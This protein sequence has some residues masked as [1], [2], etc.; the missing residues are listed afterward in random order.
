MQT[1]GL[2]CNI[3]FVIFFAFLWYDGVLDVRILPEQEQEV[4]SIQNPSL[5]TYLSQFDTHSDEELISL[6][7]D[8]GH[9]LNGY[10]V[11]ELALALLKERGYVVADP[12]QAYNGWPQP[13]Q[14]I[15]LSDKKTIHLF[16][17]LTSE[18]IAQ[19]KTYYEQVVVPFTAERIVQELDRDNE[20]YSQALIRTDEWARFSEV[21]PHL[22]LEERIALAREL[23]GALF[24]ETPKK[25]PLEL[26]QVS[27]SPLLALYLASYEMNAL[28]TQAD[29]RTLSAIFAL[30]PK[31][32][33]AGIRLSLR[34]L[35]AAR[36]P[37]IWKR[38]QE[39]LASALSVPDIAYVSRDEVVAHLKQL[40]AAKKP[41]PTP[42]E[43]A[44][45]SIQEEIALRAA[46]RQLSPYKT[47]IVQKGDTLWSIAKRFHVNVDKLKY[48]NHI[49]GAKLSPGTELKIPH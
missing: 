25:S 49:K 36:K 28:L 44:K 23:G 39:F 4:Q 26:F 40:V 46:Q 38:A 30:L 10:R 17:S 45:K 14:T 35:H 37:E 15:A 7:D 1:L 43:P 8:T 18:Q 21:F 9:A 42:V 32:Q 34:T 12:L 16:S 5:E 20:L 47:Y 22:S 2:F 19:V 24:S 3:A 31:D 29:D 48:L 6:L 11:Q 41:M 33:P 13:M 27:E